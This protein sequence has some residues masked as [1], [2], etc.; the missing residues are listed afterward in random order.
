MLVGVFIH[1]PAVKLPAPPR[2]PRR[3]RWWEAMAALLWLLPAGDGDGDDDSSGNRGKLSK[4]A[5]PVRGSTAAIIDE[6]GRSVKRRGL[7]D[8]ESKPSVCP[9]GRAAA[10]LK[11]QELRKSEEQQ[12]RLQSMAPPAPMEL[13]DEWEKTCG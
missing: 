11:P 12:P 5:D 13:S 2:P 10:E 6:N 8:N 3:G 7:E 4:R 1:Q 9:R